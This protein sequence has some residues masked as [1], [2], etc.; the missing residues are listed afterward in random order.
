MH[1]V[2][3]VQAIREQ[4]LYAAETLIMEIGSVTR[5]AET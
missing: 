4:D 3:V 1:E 5:N 2:F